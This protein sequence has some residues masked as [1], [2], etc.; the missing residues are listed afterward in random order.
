MRWPM[1]R[2]LAVL[3]VL[4]GMAGAWLSFTGDARVWPYRNTL[5]Y[6]LYQA[7]SQVAP[8]GQN[9][10]TGVLAGTIR[11]RAG[12]PIEHARVL[13]SNPIG[14]TWSAETDASGSYRIA[15]LPA[16][17]YIVVAGAPGYEDGS[18][19]DMLLDRVAVRAATVTRFALDLV[20]SRLPDEL[21]VDDWQ[22]SVG[23][24]V[25]IT[26]PVPATAD[27][28]DVHFKVGGRPN[29]T[30]LFYIP[31][32]CT[33]ALPTLL[34]VYPGPADTWATVS[35]PLAQAGYAVIAVGPA[36]ALD[37]EPDVDDLVRVITKLHEG[38]FPCADPARLGMLGG[39]YSSLHVFR[40]AERNPDLAQAILVLGPPTDLFELRK[41][42]EQGSFFPPFGLDQALIALGLPSSEPERYFRYSPRFHA[43]SLHVPVMLIHSKADEVVPFTQSGLLADELKRQG[44]PYE[45]KIL[46][47]MGHYL[48]EPK[49]TPAIDDLYKTTLGFFER[50]LKGP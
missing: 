10:P 12:P 11:A 5:K 7:W 2:M 45:L 44:K 16:G 8:A 15:D 25:Q 50:E 40:L 9:G 17:K 27:V 42:F 19:R 14:G 1:R 34:T 28:Y 31:I 49:R 41:L 46:E 30:T 18:S 3:L 32:G 22:L 21:T 33:T 23:R 47:G 13:V 48:L 4:L 26:A 36:Y 35:L 37:L 29:Q 38:A 24:S 6:Y 20:P 43:R 39:S